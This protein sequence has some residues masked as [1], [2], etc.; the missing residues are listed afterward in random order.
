MRYRG[1]VRNGV[2]VLDDA[3]QLPE[4]ME[5][6][7]LTESQD[8][9]SEETVKSQLSDLIGLFPPEDMREIEEALRE[10]RCVDPDGW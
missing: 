7:I 4:G 3:G 5:V 9:R 1:H 8:P 2:V 6:S 10:C